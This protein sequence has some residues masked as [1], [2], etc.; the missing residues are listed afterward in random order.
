M[1]DVLLIEPCDFERFPVGGQ[2]S[3]AKQ[4]MTTFGN[5]LALVGSALMTH[6]QDV[7]SQNSS[8][9]SNTVSWR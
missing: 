2:L 5:R 6:L 7:G 3:F 4:M 8:T 9:V 1:P